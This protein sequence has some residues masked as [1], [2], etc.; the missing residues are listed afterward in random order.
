VFEKVGEFGRFADTLLGNDEWRRSFNVYENSI[1]ALYEACKP[2]ILG[3]PVTR[4]VAV[5][6]YLR[7]VIDSA[8]GEADIDEVARRIGELLDQSVVVD[9]QSGSWQADRASPVYQIVQKGRVWDLSRIDFDKLRAEFAATEYKNIEIA[10]LRAFIARK[11][12]QMLQANVMRADFAQ[13]LQ[14]IIDSYNSGGSSN[15]QY[16]EELL[17][18]TRDLKTEDERHLREGLTEDELEL[19][20]LLLQE[21]L[22]KDETQKV[23]LA[24]RHLL[25]RLLAESPKV[26]VQDWFKDRQTQEAVRNAVVT[27]L[28]ADLPSS[29]DRTLFKQK[30]DRVFEVM[31]D[32]ASRGRKWAA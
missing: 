2:E 24:A 29:Y 4:Q 23:K 31:M 16:F 19:Y 17:K 25:H 14:Q 32:Y 1:S 5:F 11:L 8:I 13:R 3:R 6:Q 28:D 9:W 26:L 12:E 18:F 7:G 27:V 30:C 22:S 15:E 20:D 10:D 21:G